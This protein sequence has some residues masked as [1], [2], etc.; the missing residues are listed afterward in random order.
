[1]V[2]TLHTNPSSTARPENIQTPWL[3][4]THQ[5]S[6]NHLARFRPSRSPGRRHYK[7]LAF[8]ELFRVRNIVINLLNSAS[9][10]LDLTS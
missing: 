1:M 10:Q 8:S 9:R 4:P 6:Q 3:F 2:N 5:Q 7:Y